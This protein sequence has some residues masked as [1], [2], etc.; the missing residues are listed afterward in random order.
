MPNS[1]WRRRSVFD[2]GMKIPRMQIR[3]FI[4]PLF[5]EQPSDNRDGGTDQQHRRERKEEFE[6]GAVDDDIARQSKER[7][8]ADPRPC[9]ACY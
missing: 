6:T 7:K 4:M 2:L 8:A 9:E 5:A 3:A 1:P